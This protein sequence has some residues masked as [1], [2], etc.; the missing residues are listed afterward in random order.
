MSKILGVIP[1]RLS[2]TRLK[3]KLLIKVRGKPI[4]EWTYNGAKSSKKLDR[5]MIATDSER[6]KDVAQSFGAEV[7][8]TPSEI[9]SGTDRVAYVAERSPEYKYIINIQGDEP[10]ITGEIVDAVV[11][12]LTNPPYPQI[13]TIASP[14][15]H[16][17][18]TES[19]DTVKVVV[20]D[21]GYAMY[22]SRYPVP[23]GNRTK[24]KH[25]GIYGYERETLLN[26]VKLSPPEIEKNERLEQLRAL[27][28]GIGIMVK[29]MHEASELHSLDNEYD[30][31][32]LKAK[33]EKL[34]EK[35]KD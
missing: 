4:L 12:M 25:I 24:L 29:V 35:A 15:L 20:R 26:L 19:S 7:V 6:I 21:D 10:L 14:T 33:L 16:E 3:E 2:S 30:L 31:H 17:Y 18:E 9:S 28:Y 22:F 11:D 32:I 1:A 23:F 34:D 27:Y 8:L 5:I 13:A